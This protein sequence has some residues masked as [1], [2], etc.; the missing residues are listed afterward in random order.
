MGTAVS[1]TVTSFSKTD[2]NFGLD[3]SHTS[4]S[5]NEQSCLAVD[6]V[7]YNCIAV[8]SWINKD[9]NNVTTFQNPE[10]FFYPVCSGKK[11]ERPFYSEDYNISS[12]QAGLL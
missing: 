12:R 10:R 6:E 5:Q 1:A 7:K 4:D 2:F 11:R 3:V 8:N 9:N